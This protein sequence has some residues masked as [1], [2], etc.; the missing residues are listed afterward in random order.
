MP[1]QILETD[2]A[3]PSQRFVEFAGRLI[4]LDEDG[5]LLNA[6]DWSEELA[7]QFALQDGM[8]LTDDHWRVIRFV[9]EYHLRFKSFPM[10]RLLVKGLNRAP[11]REQFTIKALY[12]LFPDTPMRRSCRYAGIP[13][14]AGCT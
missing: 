13:Q 7:V 1:A 10:P 12:A 8:E 4:P 6:E 11:G 3:G 9:R 14:P 2:A 5:H